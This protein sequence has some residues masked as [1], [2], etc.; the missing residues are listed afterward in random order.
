M[1]VLGV[2][3]NLGSPIKQHGI[4]NRMEVAMVLTRESCARGLVIV[5][6]ISLR[7]RRAPLA[8]KEGGQQ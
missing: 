5:K 6:R 7:G 1:V 2:A 3:M 4:S 8:P